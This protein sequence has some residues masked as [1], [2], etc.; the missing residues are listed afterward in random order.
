MSTMRDTEKAV[1]DRGVEGVEAH[2]VGGVGDELRSGRRTVQSIERLRYHSIDDA[3]VLAEHLRS[4]LDRVAHAA[5]RQF[6]PGAADQAWNESAVRSSLAAVG[7]WLA[8]NKDARVLGK[9][10]R[11]L[12]E[13]I[14][15]L[16]LASVHEGGLRSRVRR[17][18]RRRM[19]GA[20]VA[21]I[22]LLLALAIASG[23]RQGSQTR[24]IADFDRLMGIA[25]GLLTDEKYPEAAKAFREAIAVLPDHQKTSGAYNNLGWALQKQGDLDGAIASYERAVSL[26]PTA[27]LPQNN[28]AAARKAKGG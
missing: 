21:V 10:T 4:D 14:D 26:D 20:A 9:V 6:P 2:A 18:S 7:A 12:L 19:V 1:D 16:E 5:A 17:W 22:A 13:V 27:S 3:W 8:G 15:E 11:E 28:L 25:N 24:D 23:L